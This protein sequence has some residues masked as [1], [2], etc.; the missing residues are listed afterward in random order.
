MPY[1]PSKK[2]ILHNKGSSAIRIRLP[3]NVNFRIRGGEQRNLDEVPD[4]FRSFSVKEYIN[5]IL[6]PFERSGVIEFRDLFGNT[7]NVVSHDVMFRDKID[8]LIKNEK[9]KKEPEKEPEKE[10]RRGRGRPKGRKTRK[11]KDKE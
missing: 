9:D 11:A 4:I 10:I 6:L 5:K 7:D 2:P 1:E 3:G 8:V